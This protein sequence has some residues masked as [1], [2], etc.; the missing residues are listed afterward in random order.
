MDL[1]PL[2]APAEAPRRATIL[3]V[4]IGVTGAVAVLDQSG[5]LVEVHDMPTLQDGPKGRRSAMT[6]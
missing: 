1:P 5:T 6:R 3:G 2:D 4:D